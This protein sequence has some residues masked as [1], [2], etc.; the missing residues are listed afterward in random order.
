M[1]QITAIKITRDIC[2]IYDMGIA[3]FCVSIGI[4]RLCHKNNDMYAG[5]IEIQTGNYR[6]SLGENILCMVFSFELDVLVHYDL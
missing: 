3:G 1:I 4:K 6:Q 5:Y 2:I